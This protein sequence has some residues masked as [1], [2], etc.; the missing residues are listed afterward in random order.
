MWENETTFLQTSCI[1]WH[2]DVV[3]LTEP[4]AGAEYV[5]KWIRYL[6][7][8]SEVLP[9]IPL[10]SNAYMDF[11]IAAL[12]DYAPSAFSSW[13]EAIQEAY[14]S[15]FDPALEEEDDVNNEWLGEGEAE[16]E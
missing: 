6:E 9:E 7:Y 4:G 13:S 15:D 3:F 11:H 5:R 14:L 8:R 16:F 10:Y 12:R 2:Q 1:F